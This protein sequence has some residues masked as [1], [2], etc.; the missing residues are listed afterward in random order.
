MLGRRRTAGIRG[1]SLGLGVHMTVA[2]SRK[3]LRITALSGALCSI[4]ACG[5]LTGK[6]NTEQEAATQ[7]S[8]AHVK[9]IAMASERLGG[10]P[11]PGAVVYLS[12]AC[13]RSPTT[14]A[15]R[16]T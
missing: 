15:T 4:V 9:G 5:G 14:R 16:S 12:A 6:I 1:S 7:S 11:V 8:Q 13:A 3:Y 10:A 2:Y